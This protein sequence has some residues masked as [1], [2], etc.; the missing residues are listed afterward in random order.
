MEGEILGEAEVE[1]QTELL[2]VLGDV[3]HTLVDQSSRPV[4]R[5]VTVGDEHTSPG[6]P[7]QPDDRLDELGLPIPVDAGEPD[8]LP[9]SNLERD[10]AHLL[11]LAVVEHVETSYVE[12]GLT[13][14][15]PLLLH[16]QE[17]LTPDHR[18]GQSLL[19]R[20]L[21]R[22]SLDDLAAP[23]HRDPVRDL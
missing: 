18:A 13:G 16:A 21:T 3:P 11:D 20:A 14:L 1:H 8:D 6:R 23:E 7:P 9:R 12:Q 15:C 10:A 4:T 2:P 22:H 19:R 5:H 17:H